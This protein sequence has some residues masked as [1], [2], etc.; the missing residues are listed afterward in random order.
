M[1]AVDDMEKTRLLVEHG[2]N[3]HATSA[4]RRT[5]ILIA[6]SMPRQPGRRGV[7]ARPWRES[8]RER[9][10]PFRRY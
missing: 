7:P 8:I 10:I 4:N 2:A 1:W 3:I 9:T 6:A 5:A